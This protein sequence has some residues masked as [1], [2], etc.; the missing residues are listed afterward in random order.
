MIRFLTFFLTVLNLSLQGQENIPIGTW[1]T[2]F[3]FRDA[4]S[5]APAINGAYCAGNNS[6]FFLDLQ[7]NSINRLSKVD[8]LSESLIST[9]AYD[10]VTGTLIIAYENGTLDLLKD[11]N[12]VEI[13]AINQAPVTGSK[14]INHI[15]LHQGFAYLSAPFGVALLDL[16]KQEIREAYTNIGESGEVIDVSYGTVY[17]D[18]LFLATEQGVIAGWLDPSINLLDFTNWRRYTD[19]EGI[20]QAPISAVAVFADRLWAALDADGFYVYEGADWTRLNYDLESDVQA[21]IAENENLTVTLSESLL[22]FDLDLQSTLIDDP[23]LSLPQMAQNDPQGLWT[24]D[25]VNGLVTTVT[26]GFSS[27]YPSGP[28]SDSLGTI[29]FVD[30]SIVALPP[31]YDQLRRP[32]VTF[33]GM[34]KF[35]K[36]D[37]Q[38]FNDS[39]GLNTRSFPSVRDLVDI[40][41][42]GDQMYYFA[43]FGEG[44]LQWSLQDG[45]FQLLD[46][47]SAGSTLINAI[48]GTRNVLVSSVHHHDGTIWATNYGNSEPLH[49]FNPQDGSWGSLGTPFI[50]ARYPLELQEAQNGEFWLRL[51]PLN[52]GGIWVIDPQTGLQKHLTDVDGQGGLPSREVLDLAI[53]LEDQVWVGTAEGVALY[54]FP[55]DILERSEVDA[56]VVFIEGRPLLRDEAVNCI[57]VDGGN[58]K[59]MGTDNG[60]W[61]FNAFGDSV[62]YNFTA[63]NSPLPHN[64][65]IDLTINEENGEVFILTEAGL[66]S[67][68]GTASEGERQHLN[69]AIFPNPVT[70][71]FNGLV[72]I[73][74][75]TNN[76]VVKIADVTGK[77]VTELRAQGGTATWNV[78]DFQGRR[79]SSGV[80]LIYSSSTDGE[81]TFIGKIAVV[82]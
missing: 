15:A 68:R 44:I 63:E 28:F 51:D 74:G 11:Q 75:L 57:A 40:T 70:R 22:S 17:R 1:R 31:G 14:G 16:E 62:I 25:S 37:W 50:A 41:H 19:A 46:E 20:P 36:G 6:L 78:A 60:L 69:V 54:P 7:D 42:D 5:V 30:Q 66:V 13:T 43:S 59:W 35:Q 81:Q 47:S 56:S 9:I 79:V 80:Y 45:T 77:L 8:G 58:R 23:L 34:N 18:S 33:L 4:N 38:N 39:G 24:A 3:S 67:F 65:I 12:I 72:G 2:H 26:G 71:D 61:L 21:M 53:D 55:S 82:N 10:A 52:G 49:Q 48:P 76:A 73:S 27:I 64:R 29:H 32:L